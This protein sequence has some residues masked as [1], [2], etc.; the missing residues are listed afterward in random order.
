MQE[1]TVEIEAKTL[2][3]AREQVK[4][5]IPE[6]LHLLSEQVISDG[7]PKTVR[8]AS[9]TIEAAFT[10]AQNQIPSNAV[11]AKKKEI[12]PP[13]QKAMTVEAFNEQTARKQL[14]SQIGESEIVR[15]IRLAMAGKRGFLGFGKNQISM[16]PKCSS[17]P[18][19]K[20]R[21]NRRLKSQPR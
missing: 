14:G 3:E 6:G 18:S 12:A 15:D 5:Q 13:A 9:D 19:L 10:K 8:A 20:S 4:S 21:T 1:K 2:V 17:K 7:T 11:I 16:R